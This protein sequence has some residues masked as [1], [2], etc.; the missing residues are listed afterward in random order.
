MTVR[1]THFILNISSIALGLGMEG[2]RFR[3]LQLLQS[4]GNQTVEA[5]ATNIGLAPATIRRQ[6]LDRLIA[7]AL[8]ELQNPKP[9]SLPSLDRLFSGEC[10]F[11]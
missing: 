8:Q 2:T 9:G 5:L 4:N 11:R 1:V 10:A 6:R 3:I 7:I